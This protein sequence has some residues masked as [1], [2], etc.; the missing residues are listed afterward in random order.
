MGISIPTSPHQLSTGNLPRVLVELVMVACR[1]IT[2][3]VEVIM[4]YA[5]MLRT[6][7]NVLWKFSIIKSMMFFS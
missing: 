5:P 2:E 3:G 4:V 6:Q 1:L 7:P